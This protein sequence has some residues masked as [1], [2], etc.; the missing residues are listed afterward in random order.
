MAKPICVNLLVCERILM[1][2][3]GI[4]SVIRVVDMFQVLVPAADLPQ[5]PPV[6]MSVFG[7]GRIDESDTEKHTIQIN[8]IRPDGEVT[9][10]GPPNTF[11]SSSRIPGAPGGFNFGGVIGVF[12][13][14]LG[15]HFF[16]L[17]YD[18]EEIARVPFTLSDRVVPGPQQE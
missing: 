13:K 14:Q 6:Q 7:M 4:A 11:V 17:M 16:V 18:G 2:A 1:E 10:A 5:A 12:P 8:L 3:D 15:L 9:A